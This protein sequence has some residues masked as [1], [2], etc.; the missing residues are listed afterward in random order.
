MNK[1]II[2]SIYLFINRLNSL[3]KANGLKYTAQYLKACHI[4]CMKAIASDRNAHSCTFSPKVSLTKA[5]LPRIIPQYLRVLIRSNNKWSIKL[6]LTIFNLY[7]VLPFEGEVKLSTI[8]KSSDFSI[9]QDMNLF[10]KEYWT[11]LK[12]P[13]FTWHF[14][15]FSIK[16]KGSIVVG[17]GNSTSGIIP[18]LLAL[19]QSDLWESVRWFFESKDL[20]RSWISFNVW[21]YL[22]A[23]A[24]SFVNASG[25]PNPFKPY[26]GRLAYKEEPGKVRVFAMSDIWTQWILSSLHDSIFS[27]L[28]KIPNDGTFDQDGAVRLLQSKIERSRFVFSYDL[29]AATD[30]LPIAIQILILNSWVPN[31]G[32]HWSNLLVNRDYSVPPHKTLT[33]NIRSVRY[34]VGQP[35]GALS[36]WAMLALTHHFVVQL[37]ASRRGY[38]GW[39]TEYVVLGDDIV[40]L[41]PKV[42]AE[43]HFIMTKELCVEINLM[44]SIQSR[45]YAEFA[46]RFISADHDLS[47]ISLKEFESLSLGWN[48]IL[49]LIKKFKSSEVI[50]SRLLG[51]GSF[52]AGNIHHPFRTKR[53]SVKWIETVLYNIVFIPG[54]IWQVL[55][56]YL[57][58]FTY[59]ALLDYQ[60][61]LKDRLLA[62]KYISPQALDSIQAPW[63]IPSGLRPLN[64]YE[65]SQLRRLV[66]VSIKSFLPANF[67]P[68][69]VSEKPGMEEKITILSPPTPKYPYGIFKTTWVE[70]K[71]IFNPKSYILFVTSWDKYLKNIFYAESSFWE[72]LVWGRRNGF[73]NR[74]DDILRGMSTDYALYNDPLNKVKLW[75]DNPLNLFSHSNPR[76]HYA[77]SVDHMFRSTS[78]EKK[79]ASQIRSDKDITFQLA[80][81]LTCFSGWKDRLIIKGIS[82]PKP[83]EKPAGLPKWFRMDR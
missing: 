25:L 10:I 15:P 62:W 81:F 16:A 2:Q 5:G 3:R 19:R 45:H 82:A 17:K 7:R 77:N 57:T 58:Y 6:V 13:V 11:L 34:A 35:M 33:D 41:E 29:S 44:K 47:G 4:L 53:I 46:K 63:G 54:F 42:A 43:Y 78:S 64:D 14:N 31:L 68:D 8:T 59:G 24:N 67:W 73:L 83:I 51:R 74:V 32:D 70:S 69:S 27:I 38:K 55:D 9:P 40:I 18:S 52:S 21:F 49:S 1:Q 28:K 75:K 22:E 30:R 65:I 50:F 60:K 80:A 36:S 66:L 79:Y 71:R 23:F 12:N 20:K 26:L 76:L 48:N 37:A 72:E 61:F 39:F 56:R